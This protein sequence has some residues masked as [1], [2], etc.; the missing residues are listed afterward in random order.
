MKRFEGTGA[1]VISWAGEG[2]E[3]A[4]AVHF[5]ANSCIGG[6]GVWPGE[7][8]REILASFRAGARVGAWTECGAETRRHRGARW[9][10][11]A[12]ARW[13][14]RFGVVWQGLAR[15]GGVWAARWCAGRFGWVGWFC[16]GAGWG[17]R[18]RSARDG[19]VGRWVVVWRIELAAPMISFPFL[20]VGL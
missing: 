20:T 17:L 16:A 4:E 12:P 2:A 14:G 18:R 3:S 8:R 19:V 6:V 7:E 11:F 9:V 10:C 5:R 13:M 15:V 1:G